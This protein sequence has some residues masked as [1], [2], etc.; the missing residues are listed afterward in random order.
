MSKQLRRRE[1]YRILRYEIY[2][3]LAVMVRRFKVT[4]N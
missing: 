2:F 1:A 3:V 4:L